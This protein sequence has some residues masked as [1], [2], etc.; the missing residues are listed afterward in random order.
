[1]LTACGDFRREYERELRLRNKCVDAPANCINEKTLNVSR[2]TTIEANPVWGVFCS[3]F[4][5]TQILIAD[6]GCLF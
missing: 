4:K 2:Q 6:T 1:M 5:L 3:L